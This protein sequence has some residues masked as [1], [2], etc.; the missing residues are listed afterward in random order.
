MFRF[1]EA[2]RY[3]ANSVGE[4]SPPL[5]LNEIHFSKSGVDW[6]ELFNPL[7]TE[8]SLNGLALSTHRDL[9]HKIALSGKLAARGF[10]TVRVSLP[11]QKEEVNVY[12]IDRANT[13]LDARTF[14]YPAR[15]EAYQAIPDGAS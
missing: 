1:P 6:I 12:L 5:K 3:Q 13:V 10:T 15:A 9:K 7:Q 14:S 8:A 4:L 2:T 11:S